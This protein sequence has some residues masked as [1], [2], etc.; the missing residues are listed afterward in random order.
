[1]YIR[2]HTDYIS[3]KTNIPVGITVA[4]WHLLKAGLFTLEEEKQYK[5]YAANLEIIL[6]NPDFYDDGNSI[7]AVTWFKKNKKT[8]FVISQ[9]SFYFEMMNKYAN[10]IKKS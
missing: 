7:S 5:E 2:Y 9:M 3:P 10:D 4:V 1:M 8:E 6:P